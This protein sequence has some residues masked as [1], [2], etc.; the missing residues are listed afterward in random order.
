M[1]LFSLSLKSWKFVSKFCLC[2]LSI[3]TFQKPVSIL[4]SVCDSKVCHCDSKF[5]QYIEICLWFHILSVY[6]SLSV[7]LKSVSILK[8]ACGSKFYQYIEACL[9]LQSVP[10]D[11]LCLR[12]SILVSRMYLYMHICLYLR[13]LSVYSW[14]T[15]VCLGMNVSS[16]C[17]WILFI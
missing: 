16:W 7:T 3:S 6:L 8:S 2:Y 14:Y 9:W 5:C 11:C 17:L 1:Y 4:K 10:K 12:K 15:S 13:D